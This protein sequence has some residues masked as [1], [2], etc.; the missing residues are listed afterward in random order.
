MS[1]LSDILRED[2]FSEINRILAEADSKAEELIRD[3]KSKASEQVEALRKKMEAEYEASLRGMK[4]T[5]D[6]TV[7]IARIRA[8]DQ[9]IARVRERVMAAIEEIARKPNYGEI[10]E[11]LAEE[12]FRSVEAAEAVAVHPDDRDKLG[13]WTERKGLQLTTDP[14]LHLGVRIT[15]LGGG[16]SVENSLPERLQRGWEMLMSGVAARLWGK[17]E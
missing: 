14:A 8:R 17:P 5:R 15:T 7:S 3:A 12:A 16:R 4:S 6:L 11:A 2:V 13:A 1:K 9:E 10:L